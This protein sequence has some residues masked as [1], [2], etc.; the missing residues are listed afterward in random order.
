MGSRTCA[1]PVKPQDEWDKLISDGSFTSVTGPC[2]LC[3]R[4]VDA[5]SYCF[6]CK[7]FICWFCYTS[8][9]RPSGG[10]HELSLHNPRRQMRQKT[11]SEVEK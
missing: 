5:D 4:V 9:S 11:E 2:H 7:H 1:C 8:G 3:G 10:P 6:G